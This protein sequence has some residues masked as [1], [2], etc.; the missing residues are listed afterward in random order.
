MNSENIELKKLRKNI[1]EEVEIINSTLDLL[2]KKLK[3]IDIKI[4]EEKISN[5]LTPEYKFYLIILFILLENSEFVGIGRIKP[6]ISEMDINYLIH[7]IEKYSKMKKISFSEKDLIKDEQNEILW[8]VTIK[9]AV[10]NLHQMN[11]ID[12]YKLDNS[13]SN[14]HIKINLSAAVNL[15]DYADNDSKPLIFLQPIN[16]NKIKITNEK[17]QL[18]SNLNEIINEEYSENIVKIRDSIRDTAN[19]WGLEIP[20][21]NSNL[22]KVKSNKFLEINSK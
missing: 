16:E 14:H 19:A 11:Y 2:K 7:Q 3:Q 5:E 20:S 1:K 18:L 6:K 21:F 13:V 4:S 10:I 15:R 22:K 8:Q 9:S 12:F 17:Y